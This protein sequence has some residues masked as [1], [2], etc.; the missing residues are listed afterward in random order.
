MQTFHRKHYREIAKIVSRI[1]S[2]QDRLDTSLRLTLMFQEDNTAFDESKFRE[3]CCIP[4][5]AVKE[6]KIGCIKG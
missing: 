6:V 4:E 5:I 3:A 1:S 2:L